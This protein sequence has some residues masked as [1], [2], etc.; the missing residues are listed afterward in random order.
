[1]YDTKKE[2]KTDEALLEAEIDN[3]AVDEFA[4]AMKEN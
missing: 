3:I 2:Q 1:M 4:K